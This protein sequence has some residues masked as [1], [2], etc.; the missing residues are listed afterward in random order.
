[1]NGTGL[2]GIEIC[3]DIAVRIENEITQNNSDSFTELI[4]WIRVR[5][6][7][8]VFICSSI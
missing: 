5:L 6:F 3:A 4:N 8:V 2:I 7:E 1:V